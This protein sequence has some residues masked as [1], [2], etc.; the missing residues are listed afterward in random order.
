M[1]EELIPQ[2]IQDTPAAIRATVV[3]TRPA[4]AQA[5]EAIRSR[6]PRRIYLVG[7]GTSLYSSLAAAYTAR[8]LAQPGD[9]LV[10]AWPAGD[11]RYYTPAL[12]EQ[13]IVVGITASGEFRDVLA[14]FERLAGKCLRV[15]IT[16]VPGSSVTR[17]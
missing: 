16:H 10:L 3:E 7:N 9:P 5:A 2:E 12:S 11:F 1:T 6:S 14:I 4:A 8:M 15:G 13:D 17:L